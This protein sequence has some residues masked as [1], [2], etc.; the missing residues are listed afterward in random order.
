MNNYIFILLL[1]TVSCQ[2]YKTVTEVKTVKKV[3]VC[4]QPYA[5]YEDRDF[6]G[7]T[8]NYCGK[9]R[10]EF[11]DGTRGTHCGPLAEGDIITISK[12]IK[13]KKLEGKR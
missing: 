13:I 11:T 8:L 2:K 6:G 1:L 5:V 12:E 3:F 7:R 10:V 4:N 9:C